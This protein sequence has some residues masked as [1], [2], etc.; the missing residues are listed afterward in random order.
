MP[1][2]ER[3]ER[4]QLQKSDRDGIYGQID[5]GYVFGNPEFS[6]MPALSQYAEVLVWIACFKERTD[7]L[8]PAW[9]VKIRSLIGYKS[10]TR[11][12]KLCNIMVN[13]GCWKIHEDGSL[14]VLRIKEKRPNFPWKE[15]GQL[16]QTEGT[17]GRYSNSILHT[18]GKSAL[19][20]SAFDPSEN[21][22]EKPTPRPTL[23]VVDLVK[24]RLAEK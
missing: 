5:T 14:T 13:R 3:R 20:G 15:K 21:E 24:Q 9:L 18:K 7:H 17:K 10:V 22:E 8:K 16:G 12:E 19:S 11:W 1:T 23:S 6:A 4:E 2:R